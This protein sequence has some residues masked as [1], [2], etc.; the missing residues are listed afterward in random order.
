MGNRLDE[1]VLADYETFN[2][3]LADGHWA[4][5]NNLVSQ[6]NYSYPY[7][8]ADLLSHLFRDLPKHDNAEKFVQMAMN[9]FIHLHTQYGST[10]IS[11]WFDTYQYIISG[12]R[13]HGFDLVPYYAKIYE[14]LL[15]CAYFEKVE[16]ANSVI[17][18]AINHIG[19]SHPVIEKLRAWA[20]KSD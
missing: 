16:L 3:L 4:E 9:R 8:I 1:H 20:K 10:D 14:L 2:A 6:L 12:L 18:D 7:Q 17:E 5:A 15:T 19:E 13:D 11:W